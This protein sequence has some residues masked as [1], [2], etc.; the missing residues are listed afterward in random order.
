MGVAAATSFDR[1]SPFMLL[2]LALSTLWFFV[3]TLGLAWPLVARLRVDPAEKL[4]ASAALSVLALYLF[5]F[6]VYLLRL[7]PTTFLAL[8]V[9]AGAGMLAG[10]HALME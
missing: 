5:A 6:A 1:H 10:R 2:A 4:G 7:P 8:P 3:L 9:L